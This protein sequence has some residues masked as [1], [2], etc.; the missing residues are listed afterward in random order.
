MRDAST[1]P[2][3]AADD[4]D[5]TRLRLLGAWTLAYAT[6]I[7]ERLRTAPQDVSAVD[8]SAVD[9]GAIA[10]SRDWHRGFRPQ[11]RDRI[12]RSPLG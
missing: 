3:F 7:G 10:R 12:E 4:R 1:P 11:N 2:S 6:V 5:P 8:A 9:D